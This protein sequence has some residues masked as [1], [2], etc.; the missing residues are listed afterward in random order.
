MSNRKLNGFFAYVL[1]LV[2]TF[3]PFQWCWNKFASMCKINLW[4]M[5]NVNG[6]MCLWRFNLGEQT[7]DKFL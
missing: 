5:K 3:T 4:A 6:K 2:V 1:L 7:W